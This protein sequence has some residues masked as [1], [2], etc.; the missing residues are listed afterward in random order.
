[1]SMYNQANFLFE[2]MFNYL[3]EKYD[4]KPISKNYDNYAYALHFW[5]YV[6][7]YKLSDTLKERLAIFVGEKKS[8]DKFDTYDWARLP[9][10]LA[11]DYVLN[12]NSDSLQKL[13]KSVFCKQSSDRAHHILSVAW[14]CQS[15]D[16]S[17]ST[18]HK[19]FQV[20]VSSHHGYTE[21]NL[22]LLLHCKDSLNQKQIWLNSN[23]EYLK[24]INDKVKNMFEGGAIICDT[25]HRNFMDTSIFTAEK[26]TLSLGNFANSSDFNVLKERLKNHPL[27]TSIFVLPK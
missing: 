16:F 9:Q 15:V 4:E 22:L 26:Y 10:L 6:N 23:W 21:E 11:L 12:Y 24:S 20:N 25:F 1:M 2:Q 8:S 27:N 13:L 18:L 19:S 17:N 14:I 3:I 7:D 5:C